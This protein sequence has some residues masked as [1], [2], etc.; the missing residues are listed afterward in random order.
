MGHTPIIASIS[1][2]TPDEIARC[3]RRLEPLVAA[4]ELNIS[5]PN[6][7]GLQVFQQPAALSDLLALI[8]HDCRKPLFVKLP[9]YA[10]LPANRTMRKENVLALAHACMNRGA[11]ALTVANTLPVKD[12]SLAVGAGG[13]SGKPLLAITLAM[14][15]NIRAEV[16]SDIAINASGGIFIGKDAKAAINAGANTVQ[17]FTALVYRSPNVAQSMLKPLTTPFQA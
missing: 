13:L 11:D 3:H 5:S 1:G 10:E 9:R 4:I 14:I 2:D 6:T 8:N 15:A 16:G 17:I 7:R 12:K